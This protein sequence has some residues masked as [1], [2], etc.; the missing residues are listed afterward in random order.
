[1]NI[2]TR[3]SNLSFD[4]DNSIDIKEFENLDFDI[5]VLERAIKDYRKRGLKQ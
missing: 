1:M 2:N 5:K 4:F 3:I